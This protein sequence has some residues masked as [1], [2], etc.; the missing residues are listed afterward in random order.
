MKIA[1]ECFKVIMF[2]CWYF[3]LVSV[4]LLRQAVNKYVEGDWLKF[5]QNYDQSFFNQRPKKR[6]YSLGVFPGVSRGLLRPLFAL[7]SPSLRLL[8]T[9]PPRGGDPI[10]M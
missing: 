7:A 6:G 5:V 4:R 10:P 3:D 9:E 8:T 1:K 2:G